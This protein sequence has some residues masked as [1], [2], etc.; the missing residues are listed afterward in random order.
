MASPVL[1]YNS[2]K[3]VPVVSQNHKQ[4]AP[5]QQQQ[6]QQQQ[7]T[8]VDGG[9]VTQKK[10]LVFEM[11]TKGPVV[12]TLRLSSLPEFSTDLAMTN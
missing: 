7:Q 3:H 9:E 11:K 2:P 10:T 12:S 8:E 1:Q 4:P 5:E 6:Q